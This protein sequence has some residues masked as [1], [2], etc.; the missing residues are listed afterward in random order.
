MQPFWRRFAR[1]AILV[2]ISL[3][4][5]GY[6][7]GRGFLMAHRVFSGGA[8][9]A[10]NERVLWQTPL[11]MA[12]LGILMT[13]VLDLLASAF[14]KRAPVNVAATETTPPAE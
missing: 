12:T 11:V 4:I 7:L 3:A 1:H 8:Y 10:E 5:I 14:R 13:A 6:I 9:N 2:G